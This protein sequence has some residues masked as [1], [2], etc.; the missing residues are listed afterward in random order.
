MPVASAMTAIHRDCLVQASNTWW[1][2]IQHITLEVKL[3]LLTFCY[4]WTDNY[5]YMYND[6]L[7]YIVCTLFLK[8]LS[9]YMLTYN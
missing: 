5:N 8:N 1:P 9:K 2:E 7:H 4:R 3:F 6:I